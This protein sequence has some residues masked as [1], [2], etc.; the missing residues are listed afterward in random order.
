MEGF[1]YVT[2]RLRHCGSTGGN[3]FGVGVGVEIG[4]IEY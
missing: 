4:M 2:Y 3:E 1:I